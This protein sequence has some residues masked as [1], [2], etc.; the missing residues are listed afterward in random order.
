MSLKKAALLITA[1]LV[2]CFALTSCQ[3]MNNSSQEDTNNNGLINGWLS[4]YDQYINSNGMLCIDWSSYQPASGVAYVCC[5]RQFSGDAPHRHTSSGNSL[6]ESIESDYIYRIAI[7][8]GN[9]SLI[10]AIQTQSIPEYAWHYFYITS[11]NDILSSTEDQ[12]FRAPPVS[13]CNSVPPTAIPTQRPTEKPTRR[14]TTKPTHRPTATPN[15][16]EVP[17]YS[18]H[19]QFTGINADQNDNYTRDNNLRVGDTVYFHAHLTGGAP[20]EKILLYYEIN[21]NGEFV[22]SSSFSNVFGRDSDIWVCNT[23]FR[24]GTLSIRIFYYANNGNGRE[25]DL[26][27]TSVHIGARDDN[28]QT[29]TAKGWISGCD[30]YF[31]R[32]GNLCFD[33]T[34]YES[35]DKD[36]IWFA[37]NESSINTTQSTVIGG[38]II[39]DSP[40]PDVVY[41]YAIWCGKHEYSMDVASLGSKQIPASAWI[42]LYVTDDQQV[43]IVSSDVSIN[44]KDNEQ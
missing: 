38:Q 27:S 29:E 23:P 17:D 4:T 5:E 25:I 18:W 32:Y 22:E 35:P 8:Y 10:D 3:S 20:S 42:K 7:W 40:V 33:L 36:I 37:K 26:G 1:F 41:E 21:M 14:S 13:T 30:L 15:P 44:I 31:N 11:N 2:S 9:S 43:M 6:M 19:L 24:Y 16:T 28:T 34:N 39:W 12:F